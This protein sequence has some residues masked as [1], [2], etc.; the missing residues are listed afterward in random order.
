MLRRSPETVEEFIKPLTEEEMNYLKQENQ[1]QYA[2]LSK[3]TEAR[4]QQAHQLFHLS[5][6]LIHHDK[7]LEFIKIMAVNIKNTL[8]GLAPLVLTLYPQGAHFS[9]HLTNQ[10]GELGLTLEENY[11]DLQI[12]EDNEVI[13][14]AEPLIVL[15]GRTILIVDLAMKDGRKVKAALDYCEERGARAVYC[16]TLFDIPEARAEELRNLVPSFY[17]ASCP[18]LKLIG[19]GSDVNGFF[20]NSPHLFSVN[21]REPRARTVANFSLIPAPR[22]QHPIP[23]IFQGQIPPQKLALER[24]EQAEKTFA[25]LDLL[26]D[27]ESL[28]NQIRLT[29]EE[30][31]QKLEG[32][33]P[34][35]L[36][37][38]KGGSHFTTYLTENLTGIHLEESY[39]HITRYGSSQQGGKAKLLA[40]PRADLRGRK[41]L[42]SDDV[43]EGGATLQLAISACLEAG[44]TEVYV[45]VMGDKPQKRLSGLEFIKPIW[46]YLFDNR[47]LVGAGLDE[48][49]FFRNKWGVWAHRPAQ[50]PAL[51]KVV[52]ESASANGEAARAHEDTNV[53]VEASANANAADASASTSENGEGARAH[54]DTNAKVEASANANA[55]DAS[56]SANTSKQGISYKKLLATGAT[57]FSIGLA[58]RRL[59][60]RNKPLQASVSKLKI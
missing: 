3:Q 14:K 24:A 43:A 5:T 59:N 49:E 48:K 25:T 40:K 50:A 15:Q 29:A 20:L 12:E 32:T 10:L 23:I 7:I 8:Q 44:A 22:E 57:L 47:F 38:Q 1:K 35:V 6:M 19:F 55:A 11:L 26:W 33:R 58:V 46:C 37:M 36:S 31:R 52:N 13:F 34:V 9:N 60:Q 53:K 16:A 4:F 56:A 18:N 51:L 28:A 41:V 21:P 27:G 2:H 30:V 54:E 17:A 42:L 45:V 39:I